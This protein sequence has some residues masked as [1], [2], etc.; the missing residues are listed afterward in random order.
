MTNIVRN[1]E[2]NQLEFDSKRRRSAAVKEGLYAEHL[3]ESFLMA[4]TLAQEARN[5]GEDLL[6]DRIDELAYRI[7]RESDPVR[8]SF[9]AEFMDISIPTVRNWIKEE[10]LEDCGGSPQ[11]VGL[12]SV[13]RSYAIVRVLRNEGA[14]R[15]LMAAVLSQLEMDALSADEK[16][17]ASLRQMRAGERSPF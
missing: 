7:V 8:V 6:S 4:Q 5:C 2:S 3:L 12:E 15:E 14:S 16:L 9:V 13:A 11:R 17:A 1:A 10:I